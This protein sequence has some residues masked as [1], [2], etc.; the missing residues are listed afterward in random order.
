VSGYR[1]HDRAFTFTT[2]LSVGITPLALTF[3]LALLAFLAGRVRVPA[4]I[5]HLTA[6]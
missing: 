4:A 1:L 5:V 2:L 3:W 6:S